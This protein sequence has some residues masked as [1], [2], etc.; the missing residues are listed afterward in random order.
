MQA[1][2]KYTI[3]NPK[4][5]FRYINLLTK[6]NTY[7]QKGGTIF[8]TGKYK[9][10]FQ[11]N[12]LGDM[13]I[14]FIGNKENCITGL[15]KIEEPNVLDVNGFSYFRSCNITKDLE[16]KTG[17]IQMMNTFIK[18]I[19]EHYPNITKIILADNTYF[20]CNKY[21]SRLNLYNLY[22]FKYGCGYYEKYFN[23]ILADG[24]VKHK[25][26]LEK[27]KTITIDKEQIYQHLL[28]IF[29]KQEPNII[30]DINEFMSF[31]IDNELVYK[32]VKR[33]HNDD[34]CYIFK[35]FLDFIMTEHKLFQ[36]NGSVYYKNT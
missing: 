33:F 3:R 36:L 15:I 30:T 26:N 27:Y 21:N 16:R 14:I 35:E 29:N 28:T 24:A 13:Q 2:L 18:Y 4:C 23:F 6:K 34:L 22:L 1:D 9:F 10:D 31:L 17:T 25:L 20:D 32:F 8:G 5:N 11:E 12:D 7:I 19:K